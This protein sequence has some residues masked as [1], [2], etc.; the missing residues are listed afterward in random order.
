M[1]DVVSVCRALL[2]LTFAVI[3]VLVGIIGYKVS[4][5]GDVVFIVAFL[6]YLVS[7]SLYAGVGL[8]EMWNIFDEKRD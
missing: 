1:G 4:R 2:V 3:V 6:A 8:V 5:T 7:S